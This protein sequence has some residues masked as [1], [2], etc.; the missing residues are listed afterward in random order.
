[1]WHEGRTLRRPIIPAILLRRRLEGIVSRGSS[2]L[3]AATYLRVSVWLLGRGRLLIAITALLGRG[4][5]ALGTVRG[6]TR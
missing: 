6:L 4:P 2:W 1:M 3:G 5:V